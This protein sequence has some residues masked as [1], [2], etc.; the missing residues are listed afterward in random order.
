MPIQEMAIC[1]KCGNRQLYHSYFSDLIV[2]IELLYVDNSCKKCGNEIKYDDIL[3]DEASPT[4]RKRV[5]YHK[6]YKNRDK[7]EETLIKDGII[8]SEQE[9]KNYE[10]IYREKYGWNIGEEIVLGE[11]TKLYGDGAIKNYNNRTLAGILNSIKNKEE[12]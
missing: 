11:R 4:H 2:P 1:S 7:D 6:I 10:V 9:E 3:Y 12:D 5:R 8:T